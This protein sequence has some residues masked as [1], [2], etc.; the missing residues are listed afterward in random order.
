MKKFEKKSRNIRITRNIGKRFETHRS[1][2]TQG[3]ASD[4]FFKGLFRNAPLDEEGYVFLDRN[5]DYFEVILDI[6][7]EG[8]Q[9]K[10]TFPENIDKSRLIRELE[11]YNL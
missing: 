3:L 2:L 7:R 4:S 1:T 9:E 10:I 8:D 5:P 11:F 6:L